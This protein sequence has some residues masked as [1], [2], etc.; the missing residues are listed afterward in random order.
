MLV[1]ERAD[2]SSV[3]GLD[4][5]GA[6][7]KAATSDGRALCVPF[8]LW[9]E[10]QHLAKRLRAIVRPFRPHRL[11]VTMT[12]ELCDC[13]ATKREG[14]HAILDS[15]LRA[16]PKMQVQVWSTGGLFFGVEQARA[17]P[18]RVAA[19]NWHALATFAGRFAPQGAALL[20]DIG[21]TTT[22]IIALSDGRPVPQALTDPERLMTK[23]LVYTGVGRTPVCA[24]VPSGVARELFA[25]MQ[26]VYLYLRKLPEQPANRDTADG[27][28]A[29]RAY[30]YARLARMRCADAESFSRFGAIAL[31]KEAY[32]AQAREVARAADWVTGF[33]PQAPTMAIVSGR[34][35]FLARTAL[36]LRAKLR[37]RRVVSL[38]K[39]LSSAVSTSA[40]AYA[41]AVLAEESN[42]P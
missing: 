5:G 24:V 29:T 38:Q 1:Q 33:L 7:L 27:R 35:E 18:G 34:G 17:E 15:V 21:S 41:L 30:A 4:I 9:R 2:S 11:A 13:F 31:A 40:C 28:P 23:E 20:I 19:A 3:L 32:Y 6:N 39:R 16:T 8:A 10:P 42:A 25:T 37:C 22:D 14:V 36:K 12:G 26:D